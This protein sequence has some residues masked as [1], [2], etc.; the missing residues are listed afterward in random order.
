MAITQTRGW[1]EKEVLIHSVAPVRGAV[2]AVDMLAGSTK[3]S[4]QDLS[5]PKQY[6]TPVTRPVNSPQGQMPKAGGQ[7][8]LVWAFYRIG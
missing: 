2:T 3:I 5:Q 4:P 7:Q 8:H 1:R 6:Q